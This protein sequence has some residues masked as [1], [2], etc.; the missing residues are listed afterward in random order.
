MSS[1]YKTPS[2][3]YEPFQA[4]MNFEGRPTASELL[5]IST[6]PRLQI[7]LSR[8]NRPFGFHTTLDVVLEN[9]LIFSILFSERIIYRVCKNNGLEI[10]TVTRESFFEKILSRKDELPGLAEFFI[11]NQFEDT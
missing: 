8:Y 2:F 3:T 7:E 11:W 1:F 5:V 9:Q 10:D 6:A 4:Y